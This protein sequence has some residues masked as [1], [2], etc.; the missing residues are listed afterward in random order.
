MPTAIADVT[1]G[2]LYFRKSGIYNNPTRWG[3]VLDV[4][5][6]DYRVF[7]GYVVRLGLDVDYYL[8]D[9][10]YGCVGLAASRKS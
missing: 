3:W 1:K 9:D 10:R 4:S 6:Y 8:V 7:V 2:I 5:S